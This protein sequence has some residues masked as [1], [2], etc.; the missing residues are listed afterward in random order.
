MKNLHFLLFLFILAQPSL[1]QFPGECNY[2]CNNCNEVTRFSQSHSNLH[3]VLTSDSLLYQGNQLL[4]CYDYL[5]IGTFPVDLVFPYAREV[6]WVLWKQNQIVWSN[7]PTG[8]LPDT[9]L[10]HIGFG[11]GFL[12][13]DTIDISLLPLGNYELH[14]A[15]TALPNDSLV[16]PLTIEHSIPV[17]LISFIATSDNNLITLSWQT[18][19]ETN[20]QGFIVELYEKGLWQNQGFV[21]GSGTTT[22]KQEYI[23]TD[24]VTQPGEYQYRLQQIDYNG[25]TKVIG[26]VQIMI[27]GATQV[28]LF[29]N[30][31]NPFN[32]TTLISFY[33]PSTTPVQIDII[34]ILGNKVASILDEVL[35]A[36]YHEV[37]FQADKL[38][39]GVYFYFWQSPTNKFLRKMILTK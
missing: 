36:G 34:N 7:I 3:L 27:A 1:A 33:L 17:E 5:N 12:H 13:R 10:V 22:Y 26:S 18:A 32:S 25:S 24:K 37:L 4:T 2:F 14:A 19:T 38:S 39:S 29:G 23:F 28:E 6:S 35:P 9:H 31:P 8:E 16:L 30:F 15:L 11:Q 21:P 20:N